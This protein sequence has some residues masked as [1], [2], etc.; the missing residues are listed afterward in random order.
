MQIN[1]YDVTHQHKADG[2]TNRSQWAMMITRRCALK[3]RL[4]VKRG[5]PKATQM[6]RCLRMKL[7]NAT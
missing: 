2:R 1:L 7:V 4:F 3:L 6:R 5:S